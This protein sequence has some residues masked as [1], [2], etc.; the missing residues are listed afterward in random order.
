[1]T[2][3]VKALLDQVAKRTVQAAQA[4]APPP[5]TRRTKTKTEPRAISDTKRLRSNRDRSIQTG[6]TTGRLLRFT[7]GKIVDS[8]SCPKGIT[9]HGHWL[10]VNSPE[11]LPNTVPNTVCR[12]NVPDEFQTTS[13][14]G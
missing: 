2:D 7:T 6:K 14:E 3:D 9:A 13:K 11:Q 1:M 12:C 10:F 4:V 5:K 8:S